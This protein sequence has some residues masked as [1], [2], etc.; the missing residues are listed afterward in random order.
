MNL[1]K[2]LLT[3]NDCYKRGQYITPTGIV[4]HSTGANNPN[5]KRYVGPDDGLLGVNTNNNHWN[6]SGTGACVNAFIGKLKDGTIATYQ[7]LPWNMR[8]W[9]CASG[10]KGSYNNSHIQFEICEDALNDKSYFDKVYK[11]AVELCAYLCKLYPTIKVSNIV[12]HSEA[13]TLGYASN[14]GDVMHW[15]PKFGKNMDMFRSDVQKLLNKESTPTQPTQPSTPTTPSSTY[16][17]GKYKVVCNELNVRKG[18]GTNYGIN[19]VVKKNEVYTIVEV[20]G[21]WGKL[22]SGAGWISIHSAYCE[23]IGD[24]NVT[25]TPTQPTSGTFKVKIT[26]GDLNIRKGP[27]VNYARVG[28]ITDRGVYTIVE[29]QG[30]WGRLKSGVGWICLDGYTQRV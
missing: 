15:F 13:H 12:C 29:I 25:P 18:P 3:N 20:Q 14:H 22:K 5:L 17:T 24:A 9:G 16:T 10:P 2:L 30:A 27:G 1:H 6:M 7:T 28:C 11:E 19:Q 21:T 8:P 26:V 23:R 4:V